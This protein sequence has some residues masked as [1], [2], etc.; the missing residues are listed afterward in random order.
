MY[1]QFEFSCLKSSSVLCPRNSWI[2]ALLINLTNRGNPWP[3]PYLPFLNPLDLT[4][5][6]VFITMIYWSLVLSIRQAIHPFS[7]TRRQ[8]IVTLGGTVFLWLNAV[9]IRTLHYWGGVGFDTRSMFSSD[10]VHTS[11]SIFWTLSA[12]AVMSWGNRRQMRH[13]WM[14]GGGLIGVVVVKL[15][16]VDLANTGT[17]ERIVSFLGV[18]AICLVI[19]YIAPLPTQAEVEGQSE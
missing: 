9:L 2:G 5:I 18:G 15:F 7:L 16:T 14:A 19:G 12:F 11:L 8:R 10:L 1:L 17:I 13:V 6:F 4:Q 3:L